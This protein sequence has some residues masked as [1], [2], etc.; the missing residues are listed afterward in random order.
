ML[1]RC[2]K[3]IILSALWMAAIHARH[4]EYVSMLRVVEQQEIAQHILAARAKKRLITGT[5]VIGG[6]LTLAGVLA[7]QCYYNV[8]QFAED[9]PAAPAGTMP[10]PALAAI[11]ADYVRNLIEQQ[12]E[13]YTLKGMVKSGVVNGLI[14]ALVAFILDRAR[15]SSA[16]TQA[17]WELVFPWS[18]MPLLLTAIQKSSLAMKRYEKIMLEHLAQQANGPL[19]SMVQEAIERNKRFEHHMLV[20]QIER[21]FGLAFAMAGEE[22]HNHITMLVRPLLDALNTLASSY[23]STDLDLPARISLVSTLRVHLEQAIG[24]VLEIVQ[25]EKSDA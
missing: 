19:P 3:I 7:Y 1:K 14:A 20:L 25:D 9:V 12:R 23:I 6:G 15:D 2:Q 5:V 21:L 11:E 13:R 10:Q 16:L 8:G 4:Y 17:F 18:D 24:Q 22:K